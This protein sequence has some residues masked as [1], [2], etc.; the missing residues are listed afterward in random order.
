MINDSP[1]FDDTLSYGEPAEVWTDA[2][3]IGSGLVGAMCFGGPDG[4]RLLLNH[5]TGWSGGPATERSGALPSADLCRTA[6]D[7]ARAAVAEGRWQD[8]DRAVQA[9]QHGNPQSFLP[10][11]ELAL[12]INPTGPDHAAP[13]T[14]YRRRLDLSTAVHRVDYRRGESRIGVT[15][16]ASH[17]HNVVMITVEIEGGTAD[18]RLSLTSPLHSTVAGPDL[19]LRF[20]SNV[21]PAVDKPERPII[22]TDGDQEALDGAVAIRSIHDG[23]TD[24]ATH[25]IGRA[26]RAT[27][28]V[29][30][31]TSYTTPGARLHGDA[32]AA[33]DRAVERITVATR[34]G[35]EA[36]ARAQEDDHR[37]L[38]ARC[39]LRLGSVTD[40][41]TDRRLATAFAHGPD[42]LD[43]D[44][45]LAGLLFSY[46]RYL[47]ICSSRAGGLPANLQGI[48]NASMQPPWSS[49]FTMNI[50]LE[51]NY[52]LAEPTGLV[53]CLTPLFDFIDALATS[54]TET[55]R[56]VFDAPGWV[57]FHCS[58]AW[59]YSQ[60]VGDGSHDPC[61]A[62]WPF[63]GPWLLQHLRERLLHGG[64]DETALRAWP[65]V[66]SAAEFL[67]HR[68][69][70]RADSTLGT[71]PSTSPEN[72]FASPSGANGAT[73]ESSTMDIALVTDTFRFLLE[74]SERLDHDEDPV[75]RR[76]RTA[77]PRL[78][79]PTI[80]RAGLIAE[81]PIPDLTPQPDHRHTAHL[82]LVHPSDQPLDPALAAAAD[83]SLTGRGDESTGWSLV[84]KA[85][86]RARLRQPDHV[87]DLLRYLFRD[88]GVDRGHW[89]GGLYRN[90]FAAHP[91]FQIDAN[92]GYVTA[93]AECLLQSHTGTIDLLPALPAALGPGSVTGLVARPGVRVD[94]DWDAERLTGATLTSDRTEPIDHPVRYRD[95]VINCRLEPGRPVTLGPRSWDPQPAR[96]T[97][98]S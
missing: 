66:R 86:M 85:T 83:A 62:F 27:F 3:P 57:A 31:E 43:S 41:S 96:P 84:W 16:R 23:T 30:I 97:P 21:I 59:G 4:E 76:A 60:P 92:F 51:M 40:Q 17:P 79:R 80:D 25:T 89:A 98:A 35:A 32:H 87:A 68:L 49:D 46:G 18:L 69:I 39:R 11:A 24:E 6:L 7:E 78:P 58:D 45:G 82:Y 91:P 9:L 47:L 38:F 26:S 12:I 13:A 95:Q 90:L 22:Y 44:P 56:R 67:L 55:A 42:A 53:D 36:V 77:L 70:E 61:W 71:S 2:L 1:A 20:P 34:D 94:L 37:R 48:W 93:I 81:W 54:G 88:A 14:D 73:A 64:G 33:L 72:R 29:A 52:W 50:N 65:L 15:T 10:V 5:T 75:V 63:A 74:L 19:L 28:F 8:A